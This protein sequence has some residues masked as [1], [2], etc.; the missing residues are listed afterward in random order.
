MR[1][2]TGRRRRGGTACGRGETLSHLAIPPGG[3]ECLPAMSGAVGT[4]GTH[5]PSLRVSG[6]D[7]PGWRL[8]SHHSRGN[9]GERPVLVH[10]QGGGGDT[11]GGG[12]DHIGEC[13]SIRGGGCWGC[14]QQQAGVPACQ[15]GAPV[16]MLKQTVSSPALSAGVGVRGRLLGIPLQVEARWLGLTGSRVAGKQWF[17]L[18][19]G[20]WF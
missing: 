10:R 1:R 11:R 4:G 12:P 18:T 15:P 8:C 14:G 17:P 19:V 13:E 2:S 6:S 7:P 16:T 3:R 9:P 5:V 20:L